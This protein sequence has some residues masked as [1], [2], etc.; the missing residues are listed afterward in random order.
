MLDDLRLKLSSM[1]HGATFKE[2][3]E[4]E[5][6]K[7]ASNYAERH[8]ATIHVSK[9]TVC[10][11]AALLLRGCLNELETQRLWRLGIRQHG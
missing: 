6:T 9:I 5:P 10:L 11:S 7:S 3:F 8:G 4:Q 1:Q 2:I